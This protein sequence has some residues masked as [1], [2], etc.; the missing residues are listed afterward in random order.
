MAKITA[1]AL[2]SAC[3]QLG[4]RFVKDREYAYWTIKP[5]EGRDSLGYNVT[6]F[7]EA[8]EVLAA[9]YGG[10]ER[11]DEVMESEGLK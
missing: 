4:A 5:R 9:F 3:E 2:R 8:L 7:D 6:T 1:K 11:F 10:H